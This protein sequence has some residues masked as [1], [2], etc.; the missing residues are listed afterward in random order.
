MRN[1]FRQLLAVS[2]LG[3]FSAATPASAIPLRPEIEHWQEKMTASMQALKSNQF[4]EAVRL[5]EE[6]IELASHLDSTDIHLARSQ[7]QRAELYLWAKQYDKAEDMFNVAIATCE[8]AAGPDN[9][10]LVHP[11]SSLANFYY[12]VR[13]HYDRVAKL[14]ERILHIVEHTSPPEI[15]EVILWSRNLGTIYQQLGDYARAEP[16]FARA[17][18]LTEKN[19]PEWLSHEKLNQA[20]FYCSWKKWDRAEEIARSALEMRKRALRAEPTNIDR[21]LDVSVA[22][23]E[24]AADEF[25][26]GKL[27]AAEMTARRSLENC[28]SFMEAT[29]PDLGPRLAFLAEVLSSRSKFEESADTYRRLVVLTKSTLGSENAVLADVLAKYAAVLRHLNKTADAAALDAQADA[30]RRKLPAA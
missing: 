17:V 22:L 8:R 29:N 24:V 12:Y 5:N 23:D 6:A 26:A 16:L 11:L 9:P 7:V 14:F 21:K 3:F 10:E 2:L 20:Q 15:R 28:E 19:Q 25:G 27:E 13:P 4:A 1:I 30:I 18:S